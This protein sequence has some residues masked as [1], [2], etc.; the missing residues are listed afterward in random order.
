[1]G[2]VERQIHI[3]RPIDDVRPLLADPTVVFKTIGDFGR[4][5]KVADRP[6]GDQ[7]WDLYLRV[8]TVYIGGRVQVH[9]DTDGTSWRS[10]RGT[11]NKG[12]V[13]AEAD[14][15]GT[16]VTMRISV[17]FSGMVTGWLTGLLADNILARHLEAGLEEFRH[18]IEYGDY[19]TA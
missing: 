19:S 10:I 15:T 9:A 8:G 5:D 13:S 14:S 18:R 7:E 16:T 1:M 2:S 17:T 11:H 12:W 3:N 6:D 4:S